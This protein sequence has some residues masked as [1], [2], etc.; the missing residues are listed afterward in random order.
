MDT[1]I[2]KGQLLFGIAI[3]AYGV[4][5]LICVHLGLSVRGVPW[6]PV[7]AFWEYVTG[8]VPIAA[9]VSI[10]ANVRAR[11]TA[12]V[13]GVLFLLYVLF[14]ELPQVIARPMGISTRTVFFE[15]LAMC[16]SAWT[17]AATLQMVPPVW[18][19]DGAWNDA[20][21]KLIGAGPYLFGLSSVVF[22]IDH[23]L[24]LAVIASLVPAWMPGGMFWAYFPARHLSPRG[25]A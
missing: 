1:I 3:A 6:F 14:L 4:E 9:G 24:V 7:S 2:S 12:T 16:A 8:M 15:A 5:D 22:G 20:L 21:D 17:L 25:S 10:M 11:L 18:R 23:F 19:W 13:L